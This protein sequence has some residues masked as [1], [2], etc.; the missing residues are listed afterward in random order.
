MKAS[1]LIKKYLMD[2]HPE[3][4]AFI[5]KHY[6]SDHPGRADSGSILY[7]VAP[8]EITKFHRIDCD[9]YWCHNAGEDL[10]IWS[11]TPE[12]ELRKLLL[13]TSGQAEPF[14]FFRR[15]E[16]F[17]SR[18]PESSTDGALVTCITVPRFSYEGFEILKKEE[19]L[20]RYPESANFWNP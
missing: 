1:E 4:G 3:N 2:R 17:A 20:A 18:L 5:E 13:G 12:G 10:E 14:V 19:M 6:A 15:G 7:Y 9:E 8:G 16:I 11:F